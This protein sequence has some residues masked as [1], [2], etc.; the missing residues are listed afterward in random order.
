MQIQAGVAYREVGHRA[1]T[2]KWLEFDI[3]ATVPS[4]AAHAMIAARPRRDPRLSRKKK[5][6][7]QEG[8]GQPHS[9]MMTVNLVLCGLASVL[10]RV[11]CRV[12]D[13]VLIE[14]ILN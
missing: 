4:C 11:S 12:K 9:A 8:R 2:N 14:W 1:A 13:P 10:A 5:R 3:V 6:R 7:V